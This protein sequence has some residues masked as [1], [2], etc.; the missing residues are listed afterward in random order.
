MVRSV[1]KFS[2]FAGFAL[3]HSFGTASAAPPIRRIQTRKV[4]ITP[5]KGVPPSNRLR[6]NGGIY[7]RNYSSVIKS[8]A[9]FMYFSAE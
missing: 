2:G 3:A 6:L 5:V 8:A 9:V 7:S 1:Q 4:L